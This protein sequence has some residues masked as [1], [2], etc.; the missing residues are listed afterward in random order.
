MERSIN[1]KLS[2]LLAIVGIPMCGVG[3]WGFIFSSLYLVGN[4]Y[5]LVTQGIINEYFWGSAFL[6]ITSTLCIIIETYYL[7]IG[8]LKISTKKEERFWWFS[9]CLFVII[10]LSGLFLILQ[11]K[12]LSLGTN[13]SI[14]LEFY[15]AFFLTGNIAA[16]IE[17]NKSK[18]SI[19]Q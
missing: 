9:T 11:N 4:F 19:H 8:F 2:R 10:F 12:H 16:L 7:R 17:M 13:L 6:T 14:A 15:W 1:Y 5:V 18:R 3:V